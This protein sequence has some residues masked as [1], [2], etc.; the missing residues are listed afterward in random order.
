M[1]RIARLAQKPNAQRGVSILSRFKRCQCGQYIVSLIS[2]FIP[3]KTFLTS[4]NISMIIREE[5]I[6][7][8]AKHRGQIQ[9]NLFCCQS[10][11]V[12]KSQL[13]RVWRG[14]LGGGGG[15]ICFQ[16]VKFLISQSLIWY[17]NNILYSFFFLVHT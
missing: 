2:C 17:I 8:A 7:N 16:Y 1:L 14:R 3:L 12:G 10:K 4:I 9:S 11:W 5:N 13:K 6:E 15:G